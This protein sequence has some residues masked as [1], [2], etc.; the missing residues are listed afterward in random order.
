MRLHQHGNGR[1]SRCDETAWQAHSTACV[2]SQPSPW[3]DGEAQGFGEHI[4]AKM[5][6]T[7]M[8]ISL[9]LGRSCSNFMGKNANCDEL[10]TIYLAGYNAGS[11]NY[12]GNPDVITRHTPLLLRSQSGQL[13]ATRAAHCERLSTANKAVFLAGGVA[14][15]LEQTSICWPGPRSRATGARRAA[16]LTSEAAIYG[17]MR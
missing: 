17:A 5:L 3:S 15:L 4:R 1:H 6:P 12:Q 11:L 16:R 10:A 8:I 14:Y 2:I 7:E 13:M 9:C